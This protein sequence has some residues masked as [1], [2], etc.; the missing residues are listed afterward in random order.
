MEVAAAIQLL[1]IIVANAPGAITTAEQLY[2]IGQEF[3][4]TTNG[5]PPTADEITTLRA[6]I[7]ADVATALTPLPG[8]QPGDPD[9]PNS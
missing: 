7:D 8:A 9:F 1:Q 4:S 2:A 5:T 6:S 3:M